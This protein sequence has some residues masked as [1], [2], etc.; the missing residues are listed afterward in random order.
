MEFVPSCG[1]KCLKSGLFGL[2]SVRSEP[3]KAILDETLLYEYSYVNNLSLFMPFGRGIYRV[4]QKKVIPCRIFQI[5]KQLLRI[6]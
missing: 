5:F 3:G 4:R 2:I 1:M 6:F